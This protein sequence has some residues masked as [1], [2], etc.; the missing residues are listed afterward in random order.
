MKLGRMVAAAAA[1]SLATAPALAQ[2]ASADAGRT[3]A[4]AA[5]E[6]AIEGT[7]TIVWI[8]GALIAGLGVYLLVDDNN[9][10]PASP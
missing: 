3:A 7:P 10:K 6:S 9:D 2:A 1:L 5:G 8:L 4:P